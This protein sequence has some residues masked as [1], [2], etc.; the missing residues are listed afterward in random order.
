MSYINCLIALKNSL[1]ALDAEGQEEVI[2]LLNQELTYGK[3]TKM[4]MKDVFEFSLILS[5][6][7]M[8]EFFSR[9][10]LVAEGYMTTEE[11]S[12]AEWEAVNL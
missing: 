7:K 8:T 2:E 9:E 10:E 1:S 11:K 5:D 3:L 6:I 12:Q 4:S